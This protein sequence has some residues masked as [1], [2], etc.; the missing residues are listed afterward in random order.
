MVIAGRSP[1]STKAIAVKPASTK[2]QGV[3]TSTSRSGSRNFSSRKFPT[4]SVMPKMN[5]V[6]SWT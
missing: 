1:L 4:G 3:S 2:N 6:G 5:E